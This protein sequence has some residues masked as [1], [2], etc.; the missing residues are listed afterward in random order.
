M[1]ATLIGCW[2]DD[3]VVLRSGAN[4]RARGTGTL[5]LDAVLKT[6]KTNVIRFSGSDGWKPLQELPLREVILFSCESGW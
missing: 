5:S 1:W 4:H 3:P 6:L 2:D